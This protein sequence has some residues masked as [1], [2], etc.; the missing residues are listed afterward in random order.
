MEVQV[1]EQSEQKK[2]EL[3][4]NI[5]LVM[6]SFGT[7][8]P[9][10]IFSLTCFKFPDISRFFETSGHPA[11]YFH[12]DLQVVAKQSELPQIVYNQPQ[13]YAI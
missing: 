6:N 1:C 5:Q 4:A 7:L 8:F 11:Y 10:K 12:Q 9:D 2:M 13:L 3:N